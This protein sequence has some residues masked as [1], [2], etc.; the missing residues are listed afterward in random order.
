MKELNDL[1]SKLT[2]AEML[3]IFSLIIALIGGIPGIIKIINNFKEQ[4]K[5]I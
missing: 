2:I 1:F 4:N 5:L 3:A